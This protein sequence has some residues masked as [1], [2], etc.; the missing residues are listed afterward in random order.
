M[1]HKVKTKWILACLF[2]MCTLFAMVLP[3]HAVSYPNVWYSSPITTDNQFVKGKDAKLQ[4]HISSGDYR[5]ERYVVNIYDSYG[6]KVAEGVTNLNSSINLLNY[7]KYPYTSVLN[8]NDYSGVYEVRVK[9]Q[10]YAYGMWLDTPYR[11][12]VWNIYIFNV[13]VKNPTVKAKALK[14]RNQMVSRFN[15]FELYGDR[16]NATFKKV[17]GSKKITINE[18]GSIKIK[19]KTKK[20]KYR[21]KV[22]VTVGD[23]KKVSKTVTVKVKVK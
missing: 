17:S 11:E 23:K 4:F 8:T 18:F 16:G 13:K 12:K 14:K 5:Y 21:I 20:G 1:K 10:Y 6:D 9:T 3:V 22:K 15:V 7:E 2:F 19:K